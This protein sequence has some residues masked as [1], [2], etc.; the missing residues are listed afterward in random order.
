MNEQMKQM[1][2]YVI[3]ALVAGLVLGLLIQ[4]QTEILGTA[5]SESSE[6]ANK[7]DDPIDYFLVDIDDAAVWLTETYGDLE[8]DI[9]TAVDNVKAVNANPL[10]D[11]R[12]KIEEVEGDS[13]AVLMWSQAALSGIAAD[14]VAGLDDID[15]MELSK[16]IDSTV[17]VG[18]D[19]DPFSTTDLDID[20][21]G[22]YLYLIVPRDADG[23]TNKNIG[24]DWEAIERKSDTDL[25]WMPLQCDPIEEDKT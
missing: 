4:A 21:S 1:M 6:T 2:P 7:A 22:V 17:C 8:T 15:N 12:F 11:P 13:T 3:G 14:N 18:V 23:E 20:K 25:F 10:E 19:D 9:T 24:K 16:E 5:G